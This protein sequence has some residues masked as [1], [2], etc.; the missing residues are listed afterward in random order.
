MTVKKLS[1]RP[2]R[3]LRVPVT[4][5]TAIAAG[6]FG[7]TLWAAP[8]GA[9]PDT[10]P[11]E[12][13]PPEKTAPDNDSPRKAPPQRTPADKGDPDKDDGGNADPDKSGRGDKPALPKPD[14]ADPKELKNDIPSPAELMKQLRAE[15]ER[16]SKQ[17]K[18]VYFDL[19]ENVPDGPAAFSLFGDDRLN[20]RTLVERIGKAAAD[21]NVKGLLITLGDPGFN[22]SQA[23]EVRDALLQFRKSGKP[24]FVHADSYDTVSYLVAS[25]AS[26]VCMLEGGEIMLPGV[27]MEAMFAR[28]LL[29]KLGV[30]ADYVQI[31]EFKGADEELTRTEA[32]KELRGEMNKLTESLYNHII[33]SIAESR[34]LPR[35]VVKQTIDETILTGANAKSRGFVDHLVDQDGLRD[36]VT[37]KLG[38]TGSGEVDLVKDYDRQQPREQIDTSNPL[39]LVQSLMKKPEKEESEKPAVAVIH[40]D[41]VIQDGDVDN[42]PFGGDGVGS[43]NMRVALRLAVRNDNVKAIVIR[44]NSPGGSAL[45]SEVMWQAVRRAAA[46][47]PVVISVGD[48]AA[49]GGYY[50]A[51]AGDKI[52]ADPTAIVGSIGVVGGKI[53]YKDLFGKLGLH[54]ESF[55]Q[56]R[57]AGMWSSYEPWSERQREMVHN[58]MKQTYEQFTERVMTT[59]KGKIKDIDQVARGRIFMARQA[60]DLGMVDEIGGITEAIN[61]AASRVSLKPGEFDVQTLPRPK[62]LADYL[63]GTANDKEGGP[64]TMFNLKPKLDGKAA[65]AELP[66]IL[67]A[68]P[69]SV[70]M[71][72]GREIQEIR[73]F[74]DRPVVLIAPYNVTLK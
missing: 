36:L 72:L 4:L 14:K 54:T 61:D 15:R 25:G 41:G 65:A 39:A 19:S 24:A 43:D 7:M 58:W 22:P 59:R 63:N 55:S 27:S 23:M 3:V 48:M 2:G 49:S 42:G 45:A 52:W 50:L 16:K 31:G 46:K 66:A 40:A 12:K 35:D 73:L 44:I 5:L 64:N 37:K 68:L 30:K 62:T 33:D 28:G 32:S 26:D 20:V 11:P 1:S 56:G 6:V 47:K 34:K 51:S 70:R 53:V 71:A 74:Q 10:A 57:N 13:A 60:K 67:Q 29:D 21:K 9:K 8:L 18:V 38:G 69:P 17:P